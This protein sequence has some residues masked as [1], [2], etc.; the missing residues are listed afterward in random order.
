MAERKKRDVDSCRCS[1][2]PILVIF[3][4]AGVVRYCDGFT[5]LSETGGLFDFFKIVW[6]T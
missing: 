3:S 4:D 1:G 6:Y 5:A 2:Y